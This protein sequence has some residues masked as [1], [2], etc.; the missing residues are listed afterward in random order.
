MKRQILAAFCVLAAA[1][2]GRWADLDSDAFAR[3]S[4]S[5]EQFALDSQA[6]AGKA[7]AARSY[8]LRGVEADNVDKHKIFNGAYGACMRARGYKGGTSTLGFWHAYDL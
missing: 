5:Q 1:G 3:G 2:C 4:A 6:C 8:E 7:E